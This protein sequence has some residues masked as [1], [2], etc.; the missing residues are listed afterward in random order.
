MRREEQEE[1]AWPGWGWGA[2]GMCVQR[3]G[4]G[5]RVETPPETTVR[6]LDSFYLGSR[7]PERMFPTPSQLA[8]TGQASGH[9]DTTGT[10]YGSF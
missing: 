3:G 6:A 2:Q 1:D 10:Y 7:L 8:W 4:A 9:G 5:G